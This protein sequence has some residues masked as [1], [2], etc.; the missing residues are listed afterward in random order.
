MLLQRR[1]ES[2]IE[3]LPLEDSL[4]VLEIQNEIMSRLQTL[5]KV[6]PQMVRHLA[7]SYPRVGSK[8]FL[9]GLKLTHYMEKN[10]L[11][12]KT[13]VKRDSELAFL[14]KVKRLPKGSTLYLKK[15]KH[16]FLGDLP[17]GKFPSVPNRKRFT[18]ND[19]HREERLRMDLKKVQDQIARDLIRSFNKELL[20]F[21]LFDP[22]D[23]KFLG[24]FPRHSYR[25]IA[26]IAYSSNS[27]V[28]I[29]LRKN[30]KEI[31]STLLVEG[32]NSSRSSLLAE[33]QPSLGHQASLL[34]K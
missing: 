22:M 1:A 34:R 2:S 31:R 7:P 18:I 28:S 13:L 14:E 9:M 11:L 6:A 29:S 23:T 27:V 20:P 33:S 12:Q 24:Y 26:K 3:S 30:L 16:V 32:K 5:P 17:D 15:A 8:S 21:L 25:S 10:R 19:F 4:E